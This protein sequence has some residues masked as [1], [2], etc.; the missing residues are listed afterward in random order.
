MI[1]VILIRIFKP[2]NGKQKNVDQVVTGIR[3]GRSA[4]DLFTNAVSIG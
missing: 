3:W 2:E 1:L 4:P